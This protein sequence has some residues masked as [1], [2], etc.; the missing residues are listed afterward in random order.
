MI[1]DVYEMLA[2]FSHH[3]RMLP[4]DI[5][6]TGTPPGVGMGKNRFLAPG[7]VLECGITH[8]GANVMTLCRD[9]SAK[10]NRC[11]V[12]TIV[13]SAIRSGVKPNRTAV[14]A[15]CPKREYVFPRQNR[16]RD[17][18]SIWHRL[19]TRGDDAFLRREGGQSR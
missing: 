3:M 13:G 2:Y 16:S 4:G 17:G 18:R 6:T 8:L 14:V 15:R 19:G 10:E 1:F 12:P 5:L 11:L 7:D 9:Y